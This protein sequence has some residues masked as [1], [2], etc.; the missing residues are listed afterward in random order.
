MSDL[1]VPRYFLGLEIT[2][3]KSGIFL[4]QRKC[5][6]ELLFDIGQSGCKP[7]STSMEPHSRLAKIDGDLLQDV[8]EYRQL[9]EKLLYL[10]I[11]RPNICFIVI[12]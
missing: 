1:G 7:S 3:T 10:T 8:G 2:I 12:G 11:T 6:M 9:I 5:A 4:S